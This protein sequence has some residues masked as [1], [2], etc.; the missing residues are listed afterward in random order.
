MT[1]LHHFPSPLSCSRRSVRALTRL[2][3]V[4]QHTSS[5]VGWHASLV[6]LALFFAAPVAAQMLDAQFVPSFDNDVRAI[7]RQSDGTVIVGGSFSQVNGQNRYGLARLTATGALLPAFPAGPNNAVLAVAVDSIGRIVVGGSFAS[8]GTHGTQL[9]GRL[10]ADGSIDTTFVSGLMNDAGRNVSTLA[11]LP[12]GKIAVTGSLRT[13]SGATSIAVLN[14]DGSVDTGFNRPDLSSPLAMAVTQND[15]I[16]IAANFS[17][18]DPRCTSY[19]VIRL[20]VNGLIDTSFA[21]TM[22][23]PAKHMSVQANGRILV[24]GAIGQIDTHLTNYVARIM[25]NGGA[26]TSFSNLE[27]RYGSMAAIQEQADGTILVAGSFRW[28]TAGTS[29][30]RVARLTSS[31]A[32]DTTF[33]DPQFDGLIKA[34]SVSPSMDFIVAGLFNLAN[35]AARNRVARFATTRPDP[36]YANGFD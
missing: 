10:L 3:A 28:G 8:L 35:G 1:V 9:I 12:N 14:A 6:L 32:R 31:G 27:M 33:N 24:T 19:C 16:L 26:D 21:A 29:F 7:A 11:I 2:L 20:G 23:G 13:A 5:L 17:D 25:P 30:N 4:R 36:V 15:Q 18:E 34:I 22:V